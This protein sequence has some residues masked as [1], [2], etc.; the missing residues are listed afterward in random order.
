M[1][2]K[3]RVLIVDDSALMRQ[4]LGM[5]LAR[6][7]GIE[8]VGTAPDPYVARDKIRHLNPDVLTLDVEMPRMDG[9]AFLEK[10]MLARPMPVVMVS[11]LTDAGCATTLRAVELCAVDFVTKPRLDLRVP[12]PDAPRGRAG[13]AGAHGGGVHSRGARGAAGAGSRERRAGR[14]GPG[15]AGPL[16]LAEGGDDRV[17]A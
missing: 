11:S 7:P 12:R 1:P 10:L 13:A 9:L 8:V 16:A 4:V 14:K 5:L 15:R 3:I 17:G 2:S 6:D